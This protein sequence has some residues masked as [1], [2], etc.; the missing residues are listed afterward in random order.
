MDGGLFLTFSILRKAPPAE[1]NIQSR[2]TKYRMLEYHTPNP[3]VDCTKKADDEVSIGSTL[4]VERANN[5]KAD[6]PVHNNNKAA[7]VAFNEDRNIEY[8]TAQIF[9]DELEELWFGKND[10]KQMKDSFIDIGR[11]FQNHSSSD[12]QSFKTLI[13]KAFIACLEATEDPKSCLLSRMDEEFLRKCLNQDNRI[14]M[15][16]ASV[17]SIFCDKSSRRKK[18]RKALFRAQIESAEMDPEKR[19]EHLCELSREITRPSRL[20]AWRL[21]DKQ[22]S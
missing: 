19:A 4:T 9:E 16:R 8:E 13:Y 10:Y 14:G 2:G 15:E 5:R 22:A 12:P 11:H 6:K 3:V 7:R 21:A 17:L 1:D 20:F 18:L